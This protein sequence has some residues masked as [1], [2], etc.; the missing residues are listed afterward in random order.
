MDDRRSRASRPIL[1]AALAWLCLGNNQASAQESSP[2]TETW[3]TNIR[4]NPA[5]C[6]LGRAVRVAFA[7]LVRDYQALSGRCV[8]VRG[9]WRDSALF[10]N[11]RDARASDAVQ[12][13]RF[14]G[15]RIGLYGRRDIMDS[16]Y[17][18]ARLEVTAVGV[19][20]NCR[21]FWDLNVGV[22]GY[23]GYTVDA[24]YLALAEMYLEH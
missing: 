22:A 24:P 13:E 3:I 14:A 12:A 21:R 5:R 19:V 16:N 11:A 15:S 8:A 1:A 20:G 7:E 18:P 17:A 4:A 23:C 10:L 2:F 9:Y 6:N